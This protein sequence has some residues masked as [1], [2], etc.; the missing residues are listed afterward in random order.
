MDDD[1]DFGDLYDDVLQPISFPSTTPSQPPPSSSI[2][3]TKPSSILNNDSSDDDDILF[4]TPDP[5]LHSSH[6]IIAPR[7]QE[8]I[9][10]RIGNPG[11]N[12][13][14]DRRD[15]I[16]VSL[17]VEANGVLESQKEDLGLQYEK[18]RVLE[19]SEKSNIGG[20]KVEEEDGG[21]DGIGDFIREGVKEENFDI[22]IDIEEAG[23]NP[24]IPGVSGGSFVPR[25]FDGDE[26]EAS[27]REDSGGGDDWDDSDSDGG[28]QIVLNENSG[29]M[30]MMGGNED[31]EDDDGDEDLVIVADGDQHQHQ[32][33]QVMEEQEWGDDPTQ[34]IDGERKELG[35][36]P[37]KANGGGV[38]NVLGARVG[39][40][41]HGY[42]PHHSQFKYVRP[43]AAAVQ[44]GAIVGPGGAPGQVRPF[45]NGAP[46]AGRGRG[47]WRPP[48]QKTFQSGFGVPVW[49][50]NSSGRG[51]GTGL[52][53][54][55]PSYKTA[56]DIDIDSFEEK[57]WRFPGEQ[58]RLEATMQSRIRVYESGR[59]EQ[60]YDPDLPPE[61]AAAAGIQGASIENS[62]LGK[63]DVGQGDLAGQGRG[64]IRIRPPIPTGRAIQVEGGYGERLPSIDTRPPRMRDAD[65]IIEDSMDDDP[66]NANGSLENSGNDLQGDDANGGDTDED[67]RRNDN[68][69]LGRIPPI[70]NGRKREGLSRR[71]PYVSSVA[72]NNIHEGEGILPLLQESH[73][74]Y[75]PS[76]KGRTPAD[77]GGAPHDK[78]VPKQRRTT[79]DRH[80]CPTTE[81]GDGTIPSQDADVKHVHVIERENSGESTSV[82]QTSEPSSPDTYE[83]MGE[84]SLEDKLDLNDDIVFGD[85]SVVAEEV[86]I[87]TDTIISS[88]TL[89]DKSPLSSFKKKK[90]S[91]RVEDSPVKEIVNG[92]DL[93]T[94]RSSDTSKAR[95]ESSKDYQKRR[96]GGEDEV[97]QE[98]RSRRTGDTKRRHGEGEPNVRRKEDYIRDG[99]QEIDR[100]HVGTKGREASNHSL[101]H[102]D[103]DSN[104]THSSRVRIGDRDVERPRESWQ[105]REEDVHGRRVKDEDTRKRER[106]DEIGLRHRSKVRESDRSEK[107]EHLHSKKRLD[108]GDL[109]GPYDK[110]VDDMRVHNFVSRHDNFGEPHTKRRK[111]DEHH[112]RELVEKEVITSRRKRERDDG[113]DHRREDHPARVRDNR[114]RI[115]RDDIQRLKQQPHDDTLSSREREGRGALKSGRGFEDKSW[116]GSVRSKDESKG[117][118]SDK[119]RQ[120]EQPKRSERVENES[121][122][123]HRVREDYPREHQFN[124]DRY[125]R[126]DRSRTYSDHAMS[127]EDHKAHR[128]EKVSAKSA[129]EQERDNV[130]TINSRVPIHSKS[131]SSVAF[132]KKRNH[133][134]EV[135]PQQ[136]HSSRKHTEAPSDDEQNDSRKGRSKLERWTSHKDRDAESSS[137]KA[138]ASLAIEQLDE[139]FVPVESLGGDS[140]EVNIA[141]ESEIKYSGTEPTDKVEDDR[142]MDTVAKLKKRSERF[143]T[144]MS[145]EKDTTVNKKMEMEAAVPGQ[146]ETAIDAEIKPERP[147]RKR[148]WISS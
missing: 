85:A 59:S 91:S 97:V 84:V 25:G 61:L 58:L 102:R 115:E 26:N 67:V 73:H 108:N 93:R 129:N 68:E 45:F 20:V 144:P 35:G 148:R 30:G 10:D 3:T 120:S 50:N 13:I 125:P 132:S 112:R 53:F 138:K 71:E 145:T 118:V 133:E 90:L 87:T 2:P 75:H 6:Q 37:G 123:Q 119:R 5:K 109:R 111:D 4:R 8:R 16:R 56:F 63:T 41:T 104:S 94:T 130:L 131:S 40:N 79:H 139:P 9:P 100:N 78:R 92:D 54:T 82:K 128:S 141:G 127:K 27:R 33:H 34:L 14:E 24:M 117:L 15:E 136:R 32:H 70:Y 57:P 143:K 88:E 31:D 36:D 52:E 101:P 51:F 65:A 121:L 114:Q 44:G 55:L 77:G 17:K 122:P 22:E 99:R 96:D 147:A 106:V 48:M 80:S 126:H 1:D 86:E 46:L 116:V 12:W 113:I 23:E 95:S 140:D 98:G 11:S 28:L 83:A 42:H 103:W 19:D 18:A 110:N 107:E 137:L 135:P 124:D 49:G 142:H 29:P 21:A 38:G 62:T 43:G 134:H 66:A 7:L 39:Y 76:S 72:T 105:R 89:G 146:G 47:D 81:H 64:D 69:R 60:D 74:Q